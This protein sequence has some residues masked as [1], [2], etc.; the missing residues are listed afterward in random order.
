MINLTYGEDT[1]RRCGKRVLLKG[2]LPAAELYALKEITSFSLEFV[3][4]F[5]DIIASEFDGTSTV[6]ALT[7]HARPHTS[8]FLL[9][10]FLA[11]RAFNSDICF[12]AFSFP[13]SNEQ[14]SYPLVI[15]RQLL[16]HAEIPLPQLVCH[17]LESFSALW[18]PPRLC[19]W[20]IFFWHQLYLPRPLL[21][22]VRSTIW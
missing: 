17:W 22:R 5:L 8:S 3:Q 18:T 19:F 21:L 1:L 11:A 7:C 4:F 14:L 13:F 12:H 2:G 15:E 10:I 20:R 16:M 9:K 6:W